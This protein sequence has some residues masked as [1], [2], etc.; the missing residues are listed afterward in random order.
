MEIIDFTTKDQKETEM[1]L[2]SIYKE[3]GWEETAEDVFDNL[4]EYFHLPNGGIFL[5]LKENSKIIG[6]A[7]I[8]KLNNEEGIAKR[9]FIHKDYRGSGV[10]QTLLNALIKRAKK[11]NLSKIVLDVI[12]NNQRAIRFYEKN[13]FKRYNQKPIEEWFETLEP[14]TYFYYYLNL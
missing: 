14:E 5:L 2:R 7:A 12:K 1:F 4:Q 3:M 8:K 10:A 9:F 11:I 13:G 6:T